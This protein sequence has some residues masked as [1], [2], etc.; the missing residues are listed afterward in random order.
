M[1]TVP[2]DV[3]DLTTARRNALA[4]DAAVRALHAEIWSRV[5]AANN[6]L[7]ALLTIG[8][9]AQQL[10]SNVAPTGLPV[11]NLP[12][13]S[14]GAAG[15][16]QAGLDALSGLTYAKDLSTP[17]FDLPSGRGRVPS[18][19]LPNG[20]P[21]WVGTSGDRGSRP[22]DGNTAR[23]SPDYLKVY[24]PEWAFEL[25]PPPLSAADAALVNQLTT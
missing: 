20:T 4:N 9:G 25:T 7:A 11:I 3:S 5:R 21:L 23:P 19:D 14:S 10:A 17:S 8:S 13:W 16:W 12:A 24:L 6:G 18:G 2:V 1:R 22:V 15:Q